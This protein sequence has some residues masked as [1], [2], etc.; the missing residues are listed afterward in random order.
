M[1]VTLKSYVMTDIDGYYT[2]TCFDAGTAKC[3]YGTGA[4][5]LMNTGHTIVPSTHG[6]LTTVGYK[7]GADNCVYA[8]E[9]GVAYAGSTV[10]WCRDNLGIITQATDMQGL[11][12]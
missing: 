9:G 1:M 2:A 10:Q 8:L 12:G 6:L 7:L 5:I 4:F 3:T 11:A